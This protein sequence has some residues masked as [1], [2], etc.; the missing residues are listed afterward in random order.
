MLQGVE[1]RDEVVWRMC[2]IAS[3]WASM[4][5]GAAV[6]GSRSGEFKFKRSER[7][8]SRRSR[9]LGGDDRRREARGAGQREARGG[10]RW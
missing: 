4:A 1:T 6:R 7:S 5:V 9:G 10:W 3:S 2:S 8:T